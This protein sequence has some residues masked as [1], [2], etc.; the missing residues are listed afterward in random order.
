[1]N[2]AQLYASCTASPAV[3][4][5]VVHEPGIVTA[6]LSPLRECHTITDVSEPCTT[7]EAEVHPSLFVCIF[8]AGEST[9]EVTGRAATKK[10]G[11]GSVVVMCPSPS[12]S[13]LVADGSGMMTLA[14]EHRVTPAVGGGAI[15]SPIPFRGVLGGDRLLYSTPP[16]A[17][18]PP[19][20]TACSDELP[21]HVTYNG[22]MYRTLHSAEKHDSSGP[23]LANS[24]GDSSEESYAPMPSGYEIAPSNDAGIISNVIAAYHWGNFRMCT[25]DACYNAAYY[26]VQAGNANPEARLWETDGDGDYRISPSKR[27]AQ[28][29]GHWFRLLIR[30]PCVQA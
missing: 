28:G 15:T 20:P 24:N 16:S 6:Y 4:Y 8:R 5:V 1:M 27:A 25:L 12:Q 10:Q 11:S 13:E 2:G 26:T 19:A 22:Y 18:P 23:W 14:I 21:T 30:T 29:L 9:H 7:T 17:P 3:M